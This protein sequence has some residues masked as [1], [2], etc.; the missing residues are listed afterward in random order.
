MFVTDTGATVVARAARAVRDD[1]EMAD[2]RGVD[3]ARATDV[4]APG[5]IVVS[6]RDMRD[7]FTVVVPLRPYVVVLDGTDV[8]AVVPRLITDDVPRVRDVDAV[9]ADLRGVVVRV[10]VVRDTTWGVSV[11][12]MP[13]VPRDM[14]SES[15][16]AASAC[17]MPTQH[18]SVKSKIRFIPVYIYKMITKICFFEKRLFI[19]MYIKNPSVDGF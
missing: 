12:F 10:V 16:T 3:A 5:R 4:F 1:A 18:N 17:I 19:Y 15:R 2:W 7:A 14:A 6:V 13:A 11:D 9:F 8:R